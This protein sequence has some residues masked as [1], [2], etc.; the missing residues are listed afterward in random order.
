MKKSFF[1]ILLFVFGCSKQTGCVEIT[2]KT[3]GDGEYYFFW[4]YVTISSNTGSPRPIKS[5]SVTEEVY[6]Q[7]E[8][9]DTYC[10][11]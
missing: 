6:N 7:Y 5:G 8:V 2:N 10:V 4:G 1:L 3:E 9:G 11:D